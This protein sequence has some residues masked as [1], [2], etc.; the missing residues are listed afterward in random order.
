MNGELV[1]KSPYLYSSPPRHEVVEAEATVTDFPT[2]TPLCA[3]VGG[4][5]KGTEVL[6]SH[7]EEEKTK[8]WRNIETIISSS[9]RHTEIKLSLIR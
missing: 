8:G 4:E 2:V 5:L 9:T 1:D 7:T 6:K 3:H